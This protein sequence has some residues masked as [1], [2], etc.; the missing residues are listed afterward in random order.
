MERF[1]DFTLVVETGAP[2]PEATVAVYQAGTLVLAP[3]YEDNL[4]TP[5]PKTNPITSAP[6]TGYFHFYGQNDRY[7]IVI[8]KAGATGYS[9]ADVLLEDP[10]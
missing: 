9:W 5:T 3:I 2:L 6:V 4:P 10:A 7:D 1:Q 8:S